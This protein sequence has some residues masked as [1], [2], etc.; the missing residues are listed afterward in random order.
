MKAW[1][2]EQFMLRQW[3]VIERLLWIMAVAY[4]LATVTLYAPGL[5]RFREQAQHV[6]RQWGVVKRW[7]TVGKVAE[8]LGY[9]YHHH[10]R[11]WTHL[12]RP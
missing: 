11:A 10:T 9:D 12:W 2:L 3:D 1:G 7:L 8:A 4:A 5:A 6:L